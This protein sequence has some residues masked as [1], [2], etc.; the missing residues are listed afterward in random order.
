[1]HC[2]AHELNLVLCHTCRSKPEADNFFEILGNVYSFISTSVV[3]HQA[4]HGTQKQLGLENSEFVQLSKTKWKCQLN[5]LKVVIE[6]LTALLRCPEKV[7]TPI[8]ISVW[9]L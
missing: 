6:N 8:A 3:N 2:Y 5:S 1:M 7:A 9:Q 4:F